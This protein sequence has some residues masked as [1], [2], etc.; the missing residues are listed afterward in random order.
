M[1][2]VAKSAAL[3]STP[4]DDEEPTVDSLRDDNLQDDR[5]DNLRD[6]DAQASDDA[7]RESD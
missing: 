4:S 1:A 2:E 3:E 7:P 5:D 6:D